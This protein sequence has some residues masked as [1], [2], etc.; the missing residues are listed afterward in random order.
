MRAAGLLALLP[1]LAAAQTPP[2][3]SL[4][5]GVLLERDTSAAGGEFSI[6]AD[7]NEVFC[8]RF[9]PQ[10]YVVRDSRLTS[11][12]ALNPGENVEVISVAVEG[13]LVH[14]ARDVHVISDAPPAPRPR[15]V[16]GAGLLTGVDPLDHFFPTLPLGNLTFS[17]VV[18]RVNGERVVLHTRAGDQPILLRHDTRYVEDGE[19]VDHASLK[20]NMRVFIRGGKDIWD[21]VE[22]YQVYWGQILLPQQ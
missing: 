15:P 21:Q 4:T 8:Y 22:A 9:D 20:P 19:N 14:Y 17:G 18:Y 2:G 10:T 7:T 16:P 11:L 6:R 5:R 13:L 1:L 12:P 3:A